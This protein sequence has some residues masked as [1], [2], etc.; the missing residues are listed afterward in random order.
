MLSRLTL[1]T[2]R[3]AL[4]SLW[5][6]KHTEL[7]C[8]LSLSELGGSITQSLFCCLLSGI[9]E[10]SLDEISMQTLCTLS[11][12]SVSIFRKTLDSIEITYYAMRTEIDI[13]VRCV[14]Y[15]IPIRPKGKG[16]SI[17]LYTL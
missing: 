1:F 3:C 7:Y 11:P 6:E 12:M 4:K 16:V 13:F 17:Q 10:R 9:K 14:K 8:M 15:I 5:L 2:N